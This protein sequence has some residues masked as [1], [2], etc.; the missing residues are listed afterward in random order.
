MAIVRKRVGRV[1]TVKAARRNNEERKRES[2]EIVE[3]NELSWFPST[4]ATS[5]VRSGEL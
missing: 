4:N 3:A 2:G 1:A 5:A